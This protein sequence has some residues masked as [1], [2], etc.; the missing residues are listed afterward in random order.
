[1]DEIRFELDCDLGT[2]HFHEEVEILYVLSGR[3]AVMTEGENFVMGPEALVVF[4]SFQHHE[5]YREAGSHTLSAYISLEVMLQAQVGSVRCISNLQPEQEE[6][7]GLLRVKLALIFRDHR[8]SQ[9]ERRLYILSELFGLLGILK[10]QFERKEEKGTR[11][12]AGAE[13]M[14]EV[15]L[16][17]GK[18]YA[19]E[20][21]LQE[22]ASHFY[23]SQS[24]LSRE[25]QRVTG[26]AFS[27]Y[28]RNLRLS[29]AAYMLLQSSVSI[30][31]V[32][33]ACG[34]SNTNTMIEGFKRQ[35]GCTPGVFRK[36]SSETAKGGEQ[37][38][39]ADEVS[40]ISLFRHIQYAGELQP[41]NKRIE[42]PMQLEIDVRKG[43]TPCVLCHREAA[44]VGWA[45][46]LMLEPVRSAVR[47]AREEIGFCYLFT[48]GILDDSM[49]V[50]HEKPDGTPYLNFTYIDMIFDFEIA[51]GIKPWTE[52]GYT[53]KKLV[54][55]I[56][57]IFG[58]SC[59]N[60]PFDQERWVFLIEGF[61]RHLIERY[62][63]LEVKE[64]RFSPSPAVYSF[65]GV[66]SEREYL[67]YYCSTARA[68]RRILPDACI[69]AFG[70][71]TGAVTLPGD[72]TLRDFVKFCAEHDCMPNEFSFQ[73][74]HSDYRG[75]DKGET[76]IRISSQEGNESREPIPV[77][78][79][80][81]ILSKEI[82]AVRQ[83][84]DENGGAGL[85]IVINSWNSTIWQRDLGNDT[86]FKAAFIVKNVLENAGSVKAL[87]FNYLT[88]YSEKLFANPN[89]FHGGYGLITYQNLPK[90]GYQAYS[91][92][93]GLEK[94][95][96]ES[97]SGYAVT[98]SRNCRRIRILL[99]HYC[100]YD[101]QTRITSQI[102][103]EEQRTFDRYYSFR[104]E[105]G[106]SFRIHL[107]RLEE[108]SYDMES[109]VVNREYGSS[110]DLWMS[111][112]APKEFTERQRE[113]LERLAVPRYQYGRFQVM[114]TGRLDF[115]ALLEP[116]EIRLI[117]INK[118]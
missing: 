20:M 43:N 111:L 56:K 90:A 88:D 47:R 52:L 32:A 108:G 75:I 28:L 115:S 66:F 30:T 31:D 58:T 22:L 70:L 68:I 73:C 50:Y 17:I 110:Y 113:Y 33:L 4:N 11:G 36:K 100:H 93:N 2:P 18:H 26:M 62:G 105:G 82:K 40:Y 81:D 61:M 25:F 101:K 60:L 74:F 102:P 21:S 57:N 114:D 117:C 104:D 103:E 19:E 96:V 94:I 118:R 29:K 92:L 95:L 51:I 91:M 16:Y 77:S 67:D 89:V 107:Q 106:L 12:G 10:Q 65:Y 8:Q 1:M 37:Q 46:D 63:I 13:R 15:L 85:P 5:L 54:S 41:L 84:L 3:V 35:Y 86:C 76:E 34:F 59:I 49:D 78:E 80:P 109:Y 38:E 9:G 39:A 79:D 27:D 112:G 7:F 44:S 99:Y 42:E 53:P 87:A 97:G 48:H 64:W 45:R 69:S 98:R 6:W 24:H 72:S 116:H 83:I 14:R 71:D 55:H 23:L